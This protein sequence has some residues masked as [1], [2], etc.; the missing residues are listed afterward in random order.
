VQW[1]CNGVTYSSW[2]GTSLILYEISA[3]TQGTYVAVATNSAGSATSNSATVTVGTTTPTGT[4]PTI[5]TQPV[6][7]SVNSGANVSFTVAAAGTPTPTYQ[8]FKGSN[9]ISGATNATLTLNNVAGS[10]ADTYYAV[11]TNSAGSATSSNATLSVAS[12]AIAPTI[13]T[14]PVSQSV[15]A[16]ANVTM[17]IAA[18]GS[19]TPTYQWFKGSTALPGATNAALTINNVSTSDAGI[20]CA[21]AMNS[22]GTILSNDAT[23]TVSASAGSTAPVFTA[24]PVS[25]TVGAKSTVTFTASATGTPAPTYQW[26]KNGAAITGATNA[27]LTLSTVNKGA[28]GTYTVVATNSAGSATSAAATLTVKNR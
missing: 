7:Q 14:Q 24:Q 3:A 4:P 28:A 8:W 26:F 11:A 23:L 27:T 25:Q 17:S 21:A 12:S 22:G 18:T 1:Y 13:T 2:T 16:G 9:A 20:Y 10:D 6:S 15:T 19:P 5:T